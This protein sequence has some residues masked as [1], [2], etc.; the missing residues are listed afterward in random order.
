M[1]H[2]IFSSLKSIITARR[3]ATCTAINNRYQMRQSFRSVQML[4]MTLQTCINIYSIMLHVSK[5]HSGRDC[6]FAWFVSRNLH[7]EIQILSSIKDNSMLLILPRSLCYPLHQLLYQLTEFY[8]T[9]HR[10]YVTR[11][12]PNAL[13]YDC[14]QQDFCNIST[15]NIICLKTGPKSIPKQVLHRV[16]SS[17]SP[18]FSSIC[19]YFLRS[20]SSCLRLLPRLVVTSILISLPQ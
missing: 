12:Y 11:K 13:L 20:P 6:C 10:G 1:P 8:E 2:T 17:A 5:P 9:W 14:R 15:F 3:L 19:S 4:Y 18:S 16:R 7:G